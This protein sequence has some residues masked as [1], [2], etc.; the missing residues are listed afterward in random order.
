MIKAW[1]TSWDT[2]AKKVTI[3][4]V[5]NIIGQGCDGRECKKY[6]ASELISLLK[7]KLPNL[8]PD[9]IEKANYKFPLIV[10]VDDKT[11]QYQYVMDGNHRLQ[12]AINDGAEVKVKEFYTSEYKQLFNA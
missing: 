4:E 8:D 10:V 3:Q 5:W 6:M 1:H 9:R 11:K 12:K 2:G 7:N